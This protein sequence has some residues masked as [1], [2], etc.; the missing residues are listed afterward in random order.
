M[1]NKNL[2]EILGEIPAFNCPAYKIADSIITYK[3]AEIKPVYENMTNKGH[4]VV[5]IQD[6]Q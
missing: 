5:Y 1:I 3:N 6:K 4:Y 2:T